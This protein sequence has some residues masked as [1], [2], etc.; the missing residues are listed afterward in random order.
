[1]GMIGRYFPGNHWI[2]VKD[3][4]LLGFQNTASIAAGVFDGSI[5]VNEFRK[6]DL[7]IF[8]GHLD[9]FHPSWLLRGRFPHRCPAGRGD[10]AVQPSFVNYLGRCSSPSGLI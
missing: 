4:S 8:P 7:T 6:V 10:N 1:M 9:A 2:E 3:S 5:I